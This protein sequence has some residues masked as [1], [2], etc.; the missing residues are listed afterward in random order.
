MGQHDPELVAQIVCVAAWVASIVV[1]EEIELEVKRSTSEWHP[2]PRFRGDW[3][4]RQWLLRKHRET[5]RGDVLPRLYSGLVA[6]AILS[7][8][9]VFLHGAYSTAHLRQ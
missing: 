2:K 3:R 9:F 1:S 7:A 4:P 6:I 5:Y 8:A